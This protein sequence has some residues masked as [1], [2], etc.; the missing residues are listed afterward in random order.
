MKAT[1][2]VKTDAEW[3]QQ[4][5]PAQYEVCRRKGTER[6]FT[7]EYH[8]SKVPGTYQC[9][10]CGADLFSSDTKFDSGTGWPSFWQPISPDT[11]EYEE[12]R[13]FLHA[14]HRGHVQR[15]RRP[16]GT[17]LRRRSGAHLQALLPQFG[18]AEAG[19]RIG[20]GMPRPYT[21]IFSTRTA[22]N[23]NSGILPC[24]SRASMVSRFA[25]ASLK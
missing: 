8:D 21:A 19:A 9:V 12:D 3:R 13:S 14:P 2:I 7:G 23:L 20:R 4:L 25:A 18:V 15:L 5:T 10:C 6:A 22:Q 1:K 11:V 24:G 16:P 17:R